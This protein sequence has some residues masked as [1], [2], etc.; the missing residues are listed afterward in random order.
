MLTIEQM[1][2]NGC[3]DGQIRS[4]DTV[5][6]GG[7]YNLAGE[8]IGWGDLSKEDL[9]RLAKNLDDTLIIL[10]EHDSFWTFVTKNPG[11]TGAFSSTSEKEK[12]PGLEYLW[13][14]A[15]YI[16]QDKQI[17]FVSDYDKQYQ[18]YTRRIT[19]EKAKAVLS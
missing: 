7:W 19:R 9:T 3:H 2:K 5:H 16:V 14:K 17:L 12:N 18:D 1:K 13:Q 4:D 6:N 10:S 15:R 11:P 8:K